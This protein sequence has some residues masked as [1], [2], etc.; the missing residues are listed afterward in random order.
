LAL[1]FVEEARITGQ[2]QHP[3]IPVV[4]QVGTLPDGRPYLAMKLIKGQT[5]DAL[6]KG[7]KPSP[8]DFGRN[9]AIFES[10]SQAVAYAHAQQVIHR[11]LKPA[12]IMVGAFGEVQVM[13]WGL[14]K[15]LPATQ[16]E[17]SLDDTS[18]QT[19]I[20]SPKLESMRNNLSSVTMSGS[21]LGTPAYMPPE[22]ANGNVDEVDAQ[23]DVFGL[24]AILCVLL[25]GRPPYVLEDGDSPHNLATR[26][27]LQTLF[28]T[29]EECSVDREVIALCKRCLSTEKRLR[30]LNA[31]EVAQAVATIRAAAEERA[32]QAELEKQTAQVRAIQERL[33]RRIVTVSGLLIGL[34]LL[35]GAGISFWQARRAET[36]AEKAI[37]AKERADYQYRQAQITLLRILETF[38]DR[39]TDK[40]PEVLELQRTQSE[41]AL[42]FFDRIGA[43]EAEASESQRIDLAAAC[44]TAAR[45]Q[46]LLGRISAAEQNL[47]RAIRLLEEL[48]V[49]Q[50]SAL[51]PR[52]LLA[53]CYDYL[54]LLLQ[55]QITEPNAEARQSSQKAVKL[56]EKLLNEEPAS[57]SR[58]FNLSEAYHNL[59]TR[60]QADRPDLAEDMFER[61]LVLA[62]EVRQAKPDDERFAISLA[63]SCSNAGTFFVAVQQRAKAAAVY[64][65]ALAILE[66][67]A[68]KYPERVWIAFTLGALR[69]NFGGLLLTGGQTKQ[70]LEQYE[71]AQ[72]SF[73]FVLSREPNHAGAASNLLAVHGGRAQSLGLLNRHAD[74]VKDWDRVLELC[75]EKMRPAFRMQRARGLIEIGQLAYANKEIEQ[76]TTADQAEPIRF[77]EAAELHARLAV[78]NKHQPEEAAKHINRAMDLL[79]KA[80]HAGYFKS[81]TEL[82]FLNRLPFMQLQTRPEYRAFVQ[83]LKQSVG[84]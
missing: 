32:R 63:G 57:I 82:I 56:F 80:K 54:G 78:A 84:K 29:L 24:G 69:V 40:I 64:Q 47:R 27:N 70:A 7:R 52:E 60:Y 17:R 34:I 6:L 45:L 37:Q 35:I 14:A 41:Q 15:V 10:I 8:T 71:Q 21:V 36:Q 9:L 55:P 19:D 62:R 5:L 4:H 26:G 16:P 83:E 31:G 77:A 2:L 43:G 22:Q 81:K 38:D 51:E 18:T 48:E 65:E 61:S 23:S 39:G 30:P 44:K 1:R 28:A 12:N 67:L 79:Q 13:D 11:D 66:P 73:Q 25:I 33:R 50:K 74:S 72:A 20:G 3:G 46:L 42:A 53:T 75:S 76:V 68:K 58:K 49:E 59:A